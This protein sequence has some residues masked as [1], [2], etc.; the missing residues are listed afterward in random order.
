MR[1]LLNERQVTGYL[2]KAVAGVGEGSVSNLSEVLAI[3]QDRADRIAGIG[4]AAFRT[5]TPLEGE[6][7]HIDTFT[8]GCAELDVMMGGEG[9][10]GGEMYGFLAAT[11][12]GKS[13]FFGQRA[14]DAAEYFQGR[15]PNPEDWK[16]VYLF[17]YEDP[18][19]RIF[20]RTMA[21]AANIAKSSVERLRDPMKGDGLS[22]RGKLKPYEASLFPLDDLTQVDGEYERLQQAMATYSRNFQIADMQKDGV[23]NGGAEEIAIMIENDIKQFGR[24][25]GVVFIDSIDLVARNYASAR[26]YDNKQLT[27]VLN[28]IVRNI[29]RKVAVKY[30]IPVWVT[31]QVA[32]AN[33]G[34]AAGRGFHLSEAGISKDWAQSLDFV[35]DMSTLSKESIATLRCSKSRRSDGRAVEALMKLN[36]MYGR[37]ES[38]GSDYVMDNGKIVRRET[39][40][41]IGGVAPER[42]PLPKTSVG[43]YGTPPLWEDE[44]A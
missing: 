34:R 38:A 22:R 44:N 33:T 26:G 37:W 17:S 24:R 35:F 7:F 32:G 5:L 11:G 29:R 27:G 21:N 2:K 23:G 3:A 16:S 28:D 4:Q 41:E 10:A 6:S 19:K 40:E 31:N 13:T 9:Q 18:W 43:L 39:L 42:P 8:T 1:R 30:D 12:Q 20:I 15:S 14:I 25:P 36:G